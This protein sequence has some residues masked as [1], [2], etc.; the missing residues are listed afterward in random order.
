MILRRTIIVGL[1][2]ALA[3]FN[4]GC[5]L[6]KSNTTGEWQQYGTQGLKKIGLVLPVGEK[7][8]PVNQA[9]TQAVIKA[10]GD[11][12][13][14]YQ[15]LNPGDLANDRES[16]VYLAQNKCE[17]IITMGKSIEKDLD[18]VSRQYPEIRFAIIGGEVSQ[19][20]V[21]SIRFDKS[22]GSF[23]AGVLAASLT[24]TNLVGFVG[25]SETNDKDIRDGFARGVQFINLTQG[26]KVKV[27]VVYA[28]VTALAAAD[29]KRGEELANTLYWTGSD[30]VLSAPGKIANGVAISASH[31]KKIAITHDIK[32]ITEMPWNVYA[33]VLDKEGTAIYDLVRKALSGKA[34]GGRVSYGVAE[35]AV[36]IMLS[37]AVPE[38]T[39]YMILTVKEKMKKGEIKPFTIQ[40]PKDLVTEVSQLPVD[41]NKQQGRQDSQNQNGQSGEWNSGSQNQNRQSGEWNSDTQSQN[42]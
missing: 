5:I 12:G 42:Q 4:S 22:E 1:L 38:E 2:I 36:D 37:E 31:N 3:A 19:P 33:A 27:N 11:L 26:K 9:A 17:M 30:V 40:I 34:S 13:S 41:W 18:G 8:L 29:Q 23:L 39:K 6:R 14:K 16:L 21:T 24:K 32:L 28:G 20:N 35:G 7:G 10:A 25:G 15:I